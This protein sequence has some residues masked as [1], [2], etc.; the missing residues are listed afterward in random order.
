MSDMPKRVVLDPDYNGFNDQIIGWPVGATDDVDGWPEYTRKDL[1][2]ELV[3][4]LEPF[5]KAADGRRSKKI[6]GS[7]CFGQ[8]HLIKARAALAKF[9][10][11]E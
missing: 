1:I 9:R 8:T 10:E 2:T 3:A 4:A 11:G 7:V 6:I 5:A